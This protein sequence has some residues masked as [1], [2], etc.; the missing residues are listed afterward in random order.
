MVEWPLEDSVM[1]PAGWKQLAWLR[2]CSQDGVYALIQQLIYMVFP[3]PYTG[4]M[5]PGNQGVEM[6]VASFTIDPTIYWQIFFFL[7]LLL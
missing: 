2:S 5:C 6:G 3:V 4:F 7:T 1:V